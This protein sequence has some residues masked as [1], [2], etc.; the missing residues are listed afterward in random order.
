MNLDHDEMAAATAEAVRALLAKRW[1][2]SAARAAEP[3]GHDPKLWSDLCGIGLP[4]LGVAEEVG[5]AGASLAALAVAAY[6]LGRILAPAPLP[7]HAVAVRLLAQQAPEH[8]AL[9]ACISGELVATLAPRVQDGV[10]H[11]VPA[12][13]VADVV[14]ARDG[15]QLVVV[16]SGP[17]Y[18]ALPNLGN[19]PIADR[20]LAEGERLG[21][22]AGA[23]FEQA[24]REWLVLVAAWLAGASAAALELAT[25]WVKQRHQFGVPIGS[26]QGIQHGLADLPGLVDGS[27]LLA[28]EAA[29]SLDTGS[30]SMTGATGA[31][32]AV[33]AVV[34]AAD[35]AEQVTA[36]LVQYH[37]GLGVS[38]EHDAQ[39]FYRKT[40]AYALLTGS[41]HSHVRGLGDLLL[42]EGE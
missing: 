18:A 19:L 26:F 21:V 22:S 36:R 17:E 34:F 15:D 4:G 33:M 25:A 24:Y 35:T 30:A 9:E 29:W 23:A 5:G 2:V 16:R 20:S 28:Q 38:E 41:P 32:L 10:A 12:G 37:G 11:V 40:R 1:D 42:A 8:P 14:L 3:L 7:E 13:A 6:E 39:L 27:L 31:E